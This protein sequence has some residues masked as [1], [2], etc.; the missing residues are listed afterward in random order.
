MLGGTRHG[1]Q[2]RGWARLHWGGQWVQ[3]CR[4]VTWVLA[5]TRSR[6]GVLYCWWA[7]SHHV[8][9]RVC[10]STRGCLH[11]PLGLGH[12]GHVLRC[13]SYSSHGWRAGDYLAL[14]RRHSSAG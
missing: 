8:E 5:H 13:T 10:C 14:V 2:G 12:R 7:I 3:G 4:R 9:L 11:G 1:E 6:C